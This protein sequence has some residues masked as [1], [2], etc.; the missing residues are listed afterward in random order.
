MYERS[1]AP[2]AAMDAVVRCGGRHGQR[3]GQKAQRSHQQAD[4]QVMS[5][6]SVR[7]RMCGVAAMAA[8]AVGCSSS[9]PTPLSV[10]ADEVVLAYV[11]GGMSA[12]VADCLV[13]LGRRQF[14]LESLLPDA[15]SA[16]NE[17]LLDEMRRSCADAVDALSEEDLG[18]Q[19][20]FDSGP[21][22][23]GDDMYLDELYAGCAAGDGAD[24]DELW[25]EAP[26]GSAYEAYGVTCGNRPEILDCTEEMN[27]P[28][29]TPDS[30]S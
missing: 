28:D 4:G 30:V 6:F 18:E 23:V 15:V 26:V 19:A 3:M 1:F 24:C 14:D 9:E 21:F 27:G 17:L 8:I 16:E 22:N 25:E 13:G 10:S 2:I 7:V 5:L 11:D 29:M 12:D 20:D